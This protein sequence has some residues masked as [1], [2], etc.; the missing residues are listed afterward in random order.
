MWYCKHFDQLT[1]EELFI[2]LKERVRV[3]IVE[4]NCAYQEIDDDLTAIH[5]VKKD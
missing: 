3:F 2:I 5:F 1:S 4:Q